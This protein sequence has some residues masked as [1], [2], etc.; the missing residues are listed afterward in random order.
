MPGGL[1]DIL[2]AIRI[3]SDFHGLLQR[4]LLLDQIC[5]QG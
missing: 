5:E 4:R 3:T 2:A 1:E